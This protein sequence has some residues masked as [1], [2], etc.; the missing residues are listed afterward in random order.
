M[1]VAAAQFS[2]VSQISLHLFWFIMYLAI[3]YYQAICLLPKK[4]VQESFSIETVTLYGYCFFS[5]VA[6]KEIHKPFIIR[7]VLVTID[8]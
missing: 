6:T 7:P 2:A 4:I 5:W 1:F 3:T 8:Q